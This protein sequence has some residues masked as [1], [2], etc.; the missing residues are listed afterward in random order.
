MKA[1]KPYR[2]PAV[3]AEKAVIEVM[4]GPEDGRVVVCDEMPIFIGRGRENTVHL[5]YDH[6]ISRRHAKIVKSED[7]FILYDLNSINGTFVGSRR[8]REKTSIEPKKLFRV[9]A[10]QLVLRLRPAKKP[11]K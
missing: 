10:T 8:I 4:N 5:P 1:E 3:K 11:P 2:I 6:L 7:Q 9:G